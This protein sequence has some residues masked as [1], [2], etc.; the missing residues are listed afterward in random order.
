[1]SGPKKLTALLK[2][3]VEEIALSSG[4]YRL[5]TGVNKTSRIIIIIV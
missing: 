3:L 2:K 5:R 1:M 4:M